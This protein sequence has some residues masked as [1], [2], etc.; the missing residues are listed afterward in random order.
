[1]KKNFGYILSVNFSFIGPLFVN[2]WLVVLVSS[3]MVVNEG[4]DPPLPMSYD[5]KKVSKSGVVS[6]TQIDT[7]SFQT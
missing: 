3:V 6:G 5:M 2:V 4:G 7:K 1:M